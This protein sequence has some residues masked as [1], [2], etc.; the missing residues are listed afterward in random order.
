MYHTIVMVGNRIGFEKKLNR[1][2]RRERKEKKRKE[3]KMNEKKR[4][5]K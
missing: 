3:K 4:K 2:G 1:E 5:E